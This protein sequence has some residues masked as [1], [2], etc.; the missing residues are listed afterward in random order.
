MKNP[1]DKYLDHLF[2][3]LLDYRHTTNLICRILTKDA[4]NISNGEIISEN[5]SALIISDWTGP[6][7]N[8]WEIN[9]H[10][11]KYRYTGKENYASDI[12]NLI[13]RECSLIYAQAFEVLEKFIKDCLFHRAELNPK[14]Q[15]EVL[16]KFRPND[17]FTR[18]NMPG[19]DTLF[20]L[21]KIATK[22]NF[23]KHN[24]IYNNKNLNFKNFWCVISKS[25]HAITHSRGDLK[26]SEIKGESKIK[27]FHTYFKNTQTEP[28]TL[29][30]QLDYE[31]LSFLIKD[32][33]EFAFQ[34]YKML[35]LEDRCD[36]E[37]LEN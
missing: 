28:D 12:Q 14:F 21:V 6:T 24:N 11:G 35:S 30:I 33:G 22:K 16:K 26:I 23:S 4:A 19:G 7:D 15:E 13:F 29:K 36:W 10:S 8:G 31:N 27:I 37:Y 25:R 20:K 9:Q 5:H 32:L 1:Y 34:I 18:Q 3:V 2:E 17:K